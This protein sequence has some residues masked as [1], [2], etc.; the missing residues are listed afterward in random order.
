M[1]G[2]NL[3]TLENQISCTSQWKLHYFCKCLDYKIRKIFLKYLTVLFFRALKIIMSVSSC[4]NLHPQLDFFEL[5]LF[6]PLWLMRI[7]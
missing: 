7:G 3:T 2:I 5:T 6:D 1:R 4:S